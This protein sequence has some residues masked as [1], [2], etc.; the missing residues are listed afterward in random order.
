MTNSCPIF[1]G[2]DISC[3]TRSTALVDFSAADAGNFPIAER[4]ASAVPVFRSVRR[5]NRGM[6]GEFGIIVLDLA[7]KRAHN[8]KPLKLRPLHLILPRLRPIVQL[9]PV[10]ALAGQ[11]PMRS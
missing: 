7:M 1:S 9:V 2:R 6:P 8:S 4:P 10:N 5:S 3:S 11:D